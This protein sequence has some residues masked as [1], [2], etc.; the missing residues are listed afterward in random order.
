M[1]FNGKPGGKG[2]V[3]LG[4]IQ[5][6]VCFCGSCRACLHPFP[7]PSRTLRESSYDIIIIIIISRV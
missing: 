6:V 5:R 1:P 7:L 4:L 3:A 2:P